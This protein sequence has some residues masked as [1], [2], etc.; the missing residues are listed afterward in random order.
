MFCCVSDCGVDNITDEKRAEALQAL[1]DFSTQIPRAAA[2]RRL[3]LA[4][5]TGQYVQHPLSGSW[6]NNSVR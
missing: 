2:P 6:S 4:I 5:A 1:H 3:A